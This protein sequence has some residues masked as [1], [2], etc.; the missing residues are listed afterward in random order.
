[1]SRETSV[2]IWMP[3]YLKD[4]RA[5]AGALTHVQHSAL[6]YLNMLLWENGGSVPDDDRAIAAELRLTVKQWRE[7]RPRLLR[8]CT[9]SS[10]RIEDPQLVAEVEKA[11]KNQ[12]QRSAAGK[13]SAAARKANGR[14]TDVATDVQRCAGGGGDVGGS[15][16]SHEEEVG[17]DGSSHAREARLGLKV[18]D[19]GAK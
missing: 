1:M 4:Q 3:L 5:R 2:G 6:V 11:R 9:I 10:G 15:N 12:A 18:V 16:Q 8:D 13:A 14:S 19:G 7:M 17:R